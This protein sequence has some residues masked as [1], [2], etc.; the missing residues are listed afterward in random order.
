MT[1]PD[2]GETGSENA[3]VAEGSLETDQETQEQG[4]GAG[5]GGS[6]GAGVEAEPEP[7]PE[8]VEPPKYHIS[9]RRLEELNRSAV[10][11]VAARLVESCPSVA[12]PLKDLKDPQ[13]LITEISRHYQDDPDYIRTDMPLMEIVFR[14]FLSRKNEFISLTDLHY[15]L[16]ER[17]ATPVRPINVTEEGLARVLD[18]DIYYGFAREDAG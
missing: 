9:F 14:I 16:T 13:A 17:W 1:T 11:L 2:T 4:A 8:P 7:E 12:K 6:A 18:F 15:E 10:A 5:I 3:A